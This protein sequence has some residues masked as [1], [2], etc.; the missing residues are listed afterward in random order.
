M[1]LKTTV[2]IK[3]F[4]TITRM[5]GTQLRAA[6]AGLGSREIAAPRIARFGQLFGLCFF[7]GL[8]VGQHVGRRE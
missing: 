1:H 4:Q 5:R 8:L 2:L 6:A 3:F 7:H